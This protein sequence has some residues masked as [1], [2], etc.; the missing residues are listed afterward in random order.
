MNIQF[1][2][3]LSLQVLGRRTWLGLIFCTLAVGR[4]MAAE[5]ITPVVSPSFFT[6]STLITVTYDVTGT[7]LQGLSVAYAWVW[8]PGSNINAKYNINP[9]S[10][11]A[12][13][14]GV[15]G[16]A[17]PRFTK[18]T[19]A[20]RILFEI[21]F[22]PSAFFTSSIAGQSKIGILLKGN[23][24]PDGQTADAV[25]DFWNGSFQVRLQTPTTPF[26][27]VDLGDVI[28]ISAETPTAAN[29]KLLVN[30]VETA[31]QSNTTTFQY[32]HT[33]TTSS[34]TT[35]MVVRATSVAD[36][37][38]TEETSF[39]YLNSTA[40]PSAPRPAGI[41]PGINYN[42][43]DPT[44]AT[45]CLWAPN[46]TS[47]Y[48]S[49][50]FND[51]EV[52]SSYQMSRDGEYFWK[53]VTGLTAG[54]E[55]GYQYLVDE[56]LWVADPYADKILDPDD[57]YIPTAAYAGLKRYPTK[58][59]RSK[60]YENRVAVLQT[61]QAPYV[62]KATGYT[63][64]AKK[65]LIIYELLIRDFFGEGMR[66][67][68][69][70]IDTIGYFKRLG[71]NAIEL[72]PIMEFN[73][74]EG[75]G[76]NPTFM[77]APDKYYGTKAK[78]KEFIDKCHEQG[79]AVIL[80]IALNHQDIP[81]PYALMYFEFGADGGFGKPLSTNP[82][83][84]RDAKHPY[85]VFFDM[86]HESPYTQA[87]VDTVTHY[88]LNEFK[89]DGYRFDLSKGFTQ[90]T[91]CSGSQT[92]DGCFAQ[93]DDSRIALL[94]RMADQIWA[95]TPDAIVILE[96]FADNSEERELAE[97]RAGEGKGMMLWGNLNYAYNQNT[98][99]YSS[100]SDIGWIS[101]KNRSWSVP[102]VVGYMESHDE[103]RLMF[104]NIEYGATEG[105]YDVRDAYV[106]LSRMMG[107]GLLFY[108][109]PGP[110]MIW[111]FGEVGYP[112]S[113]NR[114]EN[115]SISEDCRLSEK[116][117][118][119]NSINTDEQR[120]FDHTADLLR[121]RRTYDV[122]SS[123][124]PS[125]WGG[126]SL[127]KQLTLTNSP[128]TDTPANTDDMNVHIIVNFQT[129]AD[130]MK[131]SF[132]HTGTWYDYYNQTAIAVT[133]IPFSIP[134]AAGQ[135]KMY[136]DV[137][138]DN[139]RIVGIEEEVHGEVLVYP[140]PVGDLLHVKADLPVDGLTLIDVQGRRISPVRTEPYIWS[141]QGVT[142]GFYVAEIQTTRGVQRRKIIRR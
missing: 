32:N 101:Y 115:G 141:M 124:N 13:V 106:G 100:G 139:P 1:P 25:L 31:T 35:E 84:N 80:D 12:A 23:D 118:P 132:P 72:M 116:P 20:G 138:I 48:V 28:A 113:I 87:Y 73:G 7:P 135:F 41:I 81:N 59:I 96:H 103:E 75:W 123:P 8:I 55:Y 121:L 76:Y 51:W 127:K 16:P 63:K 69:E 42:A 86:N 88:W 56:S 24:W 140:N 49:G 68:Q 44:R 66:N 111:Q 10:S 2:A 17:G 97:Y 92:N 99:G 21:S 134:L 85:N 94:K 77:F 79:I 91:R 9:A 54:E 142:P 78:L 14:T 39:A 93:R 30:G 109:Y 95:H 3:Y 27:F 136:S 5:S 61:N 26:V 18:K 53:E 110:K 89:V 125:L 36:P 70:L 62:W 82:W 107:A 60:S 19:V 29:Y 74:N 57:Q 37:L 45:L 65:D 119:W 64:P 46:K 122:F 52:S 114:C 131:A 137:P 58:A 83:F 112:E 40:S 117:P 47:V 108:T 120:L 43:S 6:P 67:Y 105:S 33:V 15:N 50:D 22:V 38:K 34:G 129:H 4:L 128:Y 126:S 104:K 130:T 71:V 102:H 11:N 133:E 98:M 90:N